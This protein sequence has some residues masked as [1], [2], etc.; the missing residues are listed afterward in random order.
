MHHNTKSKG[1]SAQR[2]AKGL[3]P[4]R[5]RAPELPR[6]SKRKFQEHGPADRS[7]KLAQE[8]NPPSAERRA[9][10]LAPFR[11]DLAKRAAL[12]INPKYLNSCT[13]KRYGNP[14]AWMERER[15]WDIA[16]QAGARARKTEAA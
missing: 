14:K 8:R 11:L 6:I 1:S 3:I 5:P 2:C 13:A 9:A 7:G 12:G 16:A 10:Q 15:L 4:V